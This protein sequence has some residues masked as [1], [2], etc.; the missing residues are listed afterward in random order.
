M[1]LCHALLQ[2]KEGKEG[3]AS[4]MFENILPGKYKGR[5]TMTF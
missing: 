1:I 5:M 3:S 2:A 4:F